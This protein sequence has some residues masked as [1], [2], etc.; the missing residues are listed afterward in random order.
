MFERGVV[1]VGAA[2][3]VNEHHFRLSRQPADDQASIEGSDRRAHREDSDALD[4]DRRRQPAAGQEG[5][6]TPMPV[7]DTIEVRSGGAG[8]SNFVIVML[9]LAIFPLFT[10]LRHAAFEAGRWA[11]SD[12]AP[13][14]SD[15]S[16]DGDD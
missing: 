3:D 13:V 1:A 14:S 12:H 15:D 7:R 6:Q 8:W 16:S 11:E 5:A 10:H 9:F 2:V 4:C